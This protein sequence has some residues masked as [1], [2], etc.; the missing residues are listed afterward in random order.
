MSKR[1]PK[2]KVGQVVH[3]TDWK[4]STRLGKIVKVNRYTDTTQYMVEWVVMERMF[5]E[6]KGNVL[7]CAG[8]GM[9]RALTKRERGQ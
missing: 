1:K 2:F 7:L 6:Q 3:C 4:G 9:V 5:F 8:K